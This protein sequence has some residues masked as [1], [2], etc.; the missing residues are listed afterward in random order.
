[1]C[2]GFI[3]KNGELVEARADKEVIVSC[4]TIESAKL[5]MLSGIGDKNELESVGISVVKDLKGVGKNLQDHLLTSV[6][7]K[8]K[9]YSGSGSQSF[10][11]TVI[12]EK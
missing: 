12:L 3:F 7:F 5:L 9:R 1:M 2:W 6:I 8:A 11:S 4:G 10:R